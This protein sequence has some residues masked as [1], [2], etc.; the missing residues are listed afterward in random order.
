MESEITYLLLVKT[1]CFSSFALLLTMTVLA[2]AEQEKRNTN[3]G[4][5]SLQLI[6]ECKYR[7]LVGCLKV[8]N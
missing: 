5:K 3:K 1:N 6:I 4:I 2:C 7:I 8:H